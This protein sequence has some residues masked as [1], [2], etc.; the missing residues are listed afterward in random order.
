MPATSTTASSGGGPVFDRRFHR[1]LI[2]DDDHLQ[3]CIRYIVRN[4]VDARLCADPGDWA[5]SSHRATVGA[6]RAPWFLRTDLVLGRPESVALY[7]AL[8]R[9]DEG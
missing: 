7:L 1:T 9:V 6:S 2:E 4:P 5:W 3:A 8:V